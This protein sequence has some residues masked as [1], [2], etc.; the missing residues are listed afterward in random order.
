MDD[1]TT[2]LRAIDRNVAPDLWEE[3]GHRVASVVPLEVERGRSQPR[4]RKGTSRLVTI[5][6]ALAVGAAGS[7]VVVRAFHPS[8]LSSRPPASGPVASPTFQEGCDDA[9]GGNL[10]PGWKKVS[11]ISGSIAFVWLTHA[12][13]N[14][15]GL[16]NAQHAGGVK[17]LIMVKNGSRVTVSIA[18]A[19]RDMASLGYATSAFPQNPDGSYRLNEGHDSV[20]FTAC[21]AGKQSW[22]AATQFIGVV[23]AT[24][25]MCLHMD[26]TT[27]EKVP[28]TAT[29]RA[30]VG[31]GTTCPSASGH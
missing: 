20:T 5:F 31:L 3:I 26:V 11:V 10:P 13:L 15:P 16:G 30:P 8:H 18:E 7:L 25:P 9:V 1:L 4:I 23:V 2:T 21:D 19:D 12:A 24:G 27:S 22:A 6:V 17:V 28:S 14:P 29:V